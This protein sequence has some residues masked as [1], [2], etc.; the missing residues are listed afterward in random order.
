VVPV[1]GEAAQALFAARTRRR[2]RTEHQ[3]ALVN[4]TAHPG[5]EASFAVEPLDASDV[6]QA[7]PL[8]ARRRRPARSGD[9]IHERGK[10]VLAAVRSARRPAHS[11]KLPR[12]LMRPVAPAA[13]KPIRTTVVPA[14]ATII[15]K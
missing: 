13:S 9:A 7:D 1:A 12:R 4:D 5:N 8:R 11:R 14:T 6:K 3:A 2:D 10:I 15:S